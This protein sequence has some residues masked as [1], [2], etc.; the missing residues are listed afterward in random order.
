ME[1]LLGRTRR[2]DDDAHRKAFVVLRPKWCEWQESTPRSPHS[3][4]VSVVDAELTPLMGNGRRRMDDMQ[5]PRGRVLWML[6]A[7]ASLLLVVHTLPAAGVRLQH[8]APTQAQ[9]QQLEWGPRTASAS[10]LV[11]AAS[12]TIEQLVMQ[13]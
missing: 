9:L 3:A 2:H 6:G 4:P 7:A 8:L 5:T 12:R 1:S 13:P 11:L 10:R